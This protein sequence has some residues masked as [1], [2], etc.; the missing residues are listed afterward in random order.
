MVDLSDPEQRALIERLF[1]ARFAFKVRAIGRDPEDCLQEVY[2]GCLTRN[3]G[4]RPFDP[5][6]STLS[7]YGYIVCRSVT[8]NFLDAAR[9]A[10]ARNGVV[11]RGQDAALTVDGPDVHDDLTSRP[12]GWR[13]TSTSN[14]LQAQGLG[15]A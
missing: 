7:T 9:R 10:D 3:K 1:W 4:T 13:W 6:V 14:R 15:S 12:Q 8:A 5:A 11:G 2:R